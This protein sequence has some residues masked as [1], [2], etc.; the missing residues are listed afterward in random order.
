MA[1]RALKPCSFGEISSQAAAAVDEA[2]REICEEIENQGGRRMGSTLVSLYM[3]EGKGCLLQC[4]GQPGIP[5]AG[6]EAFPAL[7]GSQQ[8]GADGRAG[9]IDPGAGGQASQPP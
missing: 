6:R 7:R 2:N 9:G 5:S 8:G 3:D 4:G 1:V